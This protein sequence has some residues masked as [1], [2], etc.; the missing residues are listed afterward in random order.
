MIFFIIHHLVHAIFRQRSSEERKN[1]VTFLLGT[2]AWVCA[3]TAIQNPIYR[4]RMGFF[5]QALGQG[6]MYL[7]VTDIVA[8]AIIYKN[9]WGY[10]ILNESKVLEDA[11]TAPEMQAH[12][13]QHAHRDEDDMNERTDIASENE[14]VVTNSE[15]GDAPGVG[16]F[17]NV[18]SIIAA[19]EIE[20]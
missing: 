11:P 9:Y 8:M 7:V 13:Q 6:F 18:K 5:G 17:H 20:K 16:S 15:S 2:F 4:S 1:L 19:D 12:R 14:P 3:W 10:T